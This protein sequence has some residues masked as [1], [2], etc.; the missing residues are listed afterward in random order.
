MPAG[1]GQALGIGATAH[2]QIHRQGQ[3]L[4]R[5]D[6]AP[7][8][9]HL[10]F[11]L[12]LE[13]ALHHQQVEIGFGAGGARGAGAEQQKRLHRR[14]GRNL[15]EGGFQ[16]LPLGRLHPWPQIWKRQRLGGDPVGE[17]GRLRHD[18]AGGRSVVA[19]SRPMNSSGAPKARA[20]P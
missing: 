20:R 1:A 2:D 19:K 6:M 3:G 11:G 4:Q 10:G 5:L 14:V 18:S 7:A 16:L 8:A 12:Q 9:G 17:K 15:T 13:G